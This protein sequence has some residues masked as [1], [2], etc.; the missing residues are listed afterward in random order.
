MPALV[1]ACGRHPAEI[2]LVGWPPEELPPPDPRAVIRPVAS[3]GDTLVPVHWGRGIVAARAPVV[4]LLSTEFLPEPDWLEALLPLLGGSV[5]GAAGAPAVPAT[6]NTATTAM[7][8][9][10]FSPFLPGA[11]AAVTST[12]DIPGDGACYR[13]ADILPHGDLLEE[14][15][16]EASFH[17]RWIAEGLELLLLRRALIT[18]CGG[19]PLKQAMRLRRRHGRHYGTTV[20]LRQRHTAIRHVAGAPLVPVVLT[21]R[22]LRRTVRTPAGAART[23]RV[24][25]AL[26]ALTSAWAVGEAE[27]ALEAARS[28]KGLAPP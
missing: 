21:L 18:Y 5:V 8:L 13:R 7:Y 26:L 28:G 16:W 17:R 11:A 25:P 15:F 1:R 6:A 20:V 19:I 24:I 23:L 27:G 3:A 12:A 2:L 4:A 22:V 9:L 14:G 10:R